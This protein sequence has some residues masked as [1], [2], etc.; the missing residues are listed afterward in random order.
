[1]TATTTPERR[2]TPE[3][4]PPGSG[5]WIRRLWPFLMA[6]R[7]TVYIAFGV[8]LLSQIVAAIEPLLM[9]Q[10]ID[11]GLTDHEPILIYLVALVGTA[12][13]SLWW[14]YIRRWRGGWFSLYVQYDLRNAIYERLQ[15]L[16]FAGHD[17]MHTGQLVSRSSSDVGLIQGLLQFMPIML[18]NVVMVA[19]SLIIMLFLSPPLALLM[20]VSLPA[21]L[22]VAMRLRSTVFPAT[23]DSQQHAGVVAG[24]VDEAVSGVRV[25]K[26][27][28]QEDREL[29][30]LA[31]ASR[32]LYSARAR[33]V[34]VQARYTPLL[35]AIPSFTMVAILG[36]GGWLV[37]EGHISYGT[38]FAFMT[39]VA[40]MVPP[41][42][43]L[44]GLFAIGQQARAGAARV[45]DILDTNPLITEK[46]DAV[47]MA[48]A[49]GDVRFDDVRFG[50]TTDQ[51]VLDHFDLHVAPGEV[52][53][54]V[55]TS[56]SGKSTVTALLP[57]FY[58]VGAGRITIDGIDVRDA[59]L[60]SLRHQVGVVF[61]EAFLFSE[62]VG[63]NIAYARPDASPAEI[64]AAAAAAGASGFINELPDG[65]DTLVGER[66]L[67]L[68]GGQRQRIALARAILT[69]PRILVLDDATSAVDAATEEAIHDTLRTLMV[70]RT[71]ILIAHRRSTLRL[72]QRIVVIDHGHVVAQGSH[73]ELMA[74]DERYRSLLAGPEVAEGGEVDEV[75]DLDA[76]LAGT[77]AGNGNGTGRMDSSRADVEAAAATEREALEEMA[78]LDP[79]DGLDPLTVGAWNDEV[80]ADGQR[81]GITAE[82]W[83]S[84]P[85]D[86]PRPMASVA[87]APRLAPAG[88]RGG[89]GGGLGGPT[90]GAALAATPELLAAL[91][92]L[93]PADD[94]PQVD[95]AEAARITPGQF[96]IRRFVRPW[97]K[98]LAFGFGLVMA[99]A[100][101]SLL[102]PFFVRRGLDQGV[103]AHD[104]SSLWFTTALFAVSVCID[105]AVTW[106][107]TWITGRTSERM[108]FALRIKIF[109][110]LQSLSLDY[111]D[112]ELDGRV[113]TRMTTDVDALSQLVQTGLINALVGVLTCV[114]VF[115][116]LIVLSPPLAL[117]ASSVLP[118]LILATWWYRRRSTI[119]YAAARES[120]ADVNANLQ[121]SLSGVRVAQAYVRE[122]RN[123]SGFHDVNR[124]YLTDRLGAQ[125]L[126]A[127]YFPFVLFVADIGAVIVLATGNHLVQTGAVTTGVV[128]AFL[129]YLDQFFAPIQQLSQV[130]DTWQQA[131]ASTSKIEELF[132]IPS[133][134]PPPDHPVAPG[135]LVGEIQF[136]NVHFRYPNTVGEEALS[137]IDL[138]VA[139]G[140]TVALVGETGAGKSTIVKLVS[141]FYDPVEGSVRVDGIDLRDIDLGAFRR[142][143]GIVPQEA[144][145]FTGT[146]RDNIAYGRP[147]ATDA[148]VEAAARAVGAHD[149]VAAQPAGYLSP[150]SERGRSLSAGQRQ[151]IALARARL[152]DPAILLLDEATS[153]LDL[154][155]EARV[156][157]AM[158]AVAEGR[159]T[160]LV[161]HRL[162]TA[163]R[164]DR[165]VVIDRGRIVEEGTHDDLVALGGR[166][167]AL[168]A[169]FATATPAA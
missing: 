153:Q 155:S 80:P 52:V 72:A 86:G 9:R 38:F 51:P 162:P 83:P 34:R 85:G 59:T 128:I 64:E 111:Y 24:V 103:A 147:D 125:R 40:L 15:R 131:A 47:E 32:D 127:I 16:D 94:L 29:A 115:V 158:G 76:G 163:R 143:I 98:W 65:Y 102:G 61:E 104:L 105:W 77:F 36:M 10:I 33:L 74:Q 112:T 48:P 165:I 13:L 109:S 168:W 122:D 124:R 96:L 97:T 123:I 19:L 54:L 150:V 142:Q 140:E 70:D 12:L 22:L 166:Y 107:Y 75:D 100:L 130:L 99:D 151:L 114:G 137:G 17:Q 46:A 157:R 20:F 113:M 53:A 120:I 66:G 129:L 167:A 93:P 43:M 119:A 14:T 67:T 92:K 7:A 116:F 144:F 50:Y 18:G 4:A 68:S 37:T 79:V 81:V 78:A 49:L 146:L 73:D 45:L 58:D 145:L 164:A 169:A 82:A 87:T 141:R 1:V 21:L 8:A 56:G 149:F 39:Y 57:R 89:V 71:T 28:G 41:V 118:P 101:L 132:T 139:P 26:G 11:K 133:G 91:D 5:G 42:R 30:H 35:A 136:D 69:N 2:A 108:L 110:H 106:G 84:A 88:N 159:T 95:E 44:A 25:V 90:G 161:A 60:D 152:V 3:P 27:F 148:E 6:H 31:D 138:T 55:G 121:E 135:A 156:Q 154:A 23:W 117:A 126:I 160:L 134:T 63:A 62:S